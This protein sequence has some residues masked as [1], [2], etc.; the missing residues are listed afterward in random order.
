MVGALPYPGSIDP[1]LT[2]CHAS[3][4]GLFATLLALREIGRHAHAF[5]QRRSTLREGLRR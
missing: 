5:P 4:V 3:G 2:I 1:G